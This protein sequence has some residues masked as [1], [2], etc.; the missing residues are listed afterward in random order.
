[1]TGLLRAY[2]LLGVTLSIGGRFLVHFLSG[3]WFFW[4][5]APEGVSPIVYS[6]MYNGSY[7]VVELAISL[8]IIDIIQKR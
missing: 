2:P 8:V 5:Y 3:T 7:M 6:D 1:M 4:M